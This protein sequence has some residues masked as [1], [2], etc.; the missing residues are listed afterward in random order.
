MTG[1]PYSFEIQPVIPKALEGLNDLAN[2]LLYSW[3]ATVRGLFVRLSSELW[4]QTG[5]SPK[6]FLRRI[7]QE[8]LDAAVE[9]HIFMQDYNRVLSSYEAYKTYRHEIRSGI[10]TLLDPEKD[11]IAYFCAEFGL[12]E[13]FPIYSGGLGILAGDHCKAASDLGV[14]FIAVGLLYREGYFQ[15]TID[16]SGQQIAHYCRNAPEDL[17]ITPATDEQGQEIRVA[18]ELPGR[19]VQLRVWTTKAG[20][21]SLMLLDSDLPENSEAD[22]R[23]TYQLYGGDII[24]RIQ[25]EIVLGIGGVRA[26][27]ATGHAPTAWHINE[28]HAAF[29]ILERCRKW[30]TEGGLDFD[31]ALEIVAAGTTFTTHTP[32]PAGHDIFDKALILEYFGHYIQDLGI[33]EERFLSLG[34]FSRPEAFNMTSLALRGSRHHNGVSRIH[35]GVASHMES[36]IWPEVPHDENPITYVTNGVHVQTFLAREWANLFD[37]QFGGSWRAKLLDNDYWQVIDDIPSHNFWSVRQSLKSKLFH[38]VYERVT[39]QYLRNGYSPTQINRLTHYLSNAEANVLTVGFARRFATYKRATL[40]F[41]DLERLA[42]IVNDPERPVMFI[43]AG[44]AHPSDIPGQ[45]LIKR[46]HEISLRPEFI[47]KIILVEGYDLALSRKLVAGVDVWLNNPLY[48]NE[49]SGTSGEKAGINGVLN[50]SVLDGWWGEGYNGENGWA[51]SPHSGGHFSEDFINQ[52]EAGEL[53]DIIEHQV[54][55][56]YYDRNG[57]GYPD[58]WVRMSKASIRSLMPRFNS[59][60]MVMDYVKKFYSKTVRQRTVYIDDDCKVA[61]NIARWK[62]GIRQAWPGVT[63]RPAGTTP[64]TLVTGEKMTVEADIELNGLDASDVRVECLL[65]YETEQDT[66]QVRKTYELKKVG[67]TEGGTTRFS[68]DLVSPLPGKQAYKVRVYPH[69]PHLTTPFE[70]GLMRWM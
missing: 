63:I 46:I 10:E 27:R 44:K 32:V 14:P 62:Q 8:R 19:Q 7:S 21:I 60:R 31:T 37:M 24:T 30:I 12:H 40:L 50:L 13:S 57:H 43:F 64:A 9:D 1:T 4:E 5:H 2:D 16:S 35:G 53:L 45:E 38:D 22:R 34:R 47:G 33:D 48:P 29:Q 67:Q 66:F 6:V 59:Q 42:R 17:P 49:A 3:D 54:V 52:E 51:I 15:Q 11:L 18:V 23:I 61:K 26:L 65:G 36:Y 55:P 69:H 68:L 58:D 28:G 20:N 41:H 25:Q 56:M 39:R 70:L